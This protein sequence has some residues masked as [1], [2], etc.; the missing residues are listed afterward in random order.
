MSAR[1]GHCRGRLPCAETST[2]GGA[3]PWGPSALRA[4]ASPS[5]PPNKKNKLNKTKIF[6]R[7]VKGVREAP[8]KALVT[9]LAA[10]AGEPA[11]AAF[12]LRQSLSTL[13]MLLGSGVAAAAFELS[14]AWGRRGVARPPAPPHPTPPHP[15]HLPT[16]TPLPGPLQ[17]VPTWVCCCLPAFHPNTSTTTTTT[18]AA[19][20]DTTTRVQAAP[21][22]SPL[23]SP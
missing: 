20:T 5:S 2:A 18:T 7:T 11:A 16:P 3:G 8:S 12:G 6:D 15:T 23:H 17:L 14:G 13:G 10:A 21:T 1:V 22:S 9:E 4:W 19:D